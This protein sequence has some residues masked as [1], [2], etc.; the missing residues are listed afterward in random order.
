M[1]QVDGDIEIGDRDFD[2]LALL[3]E[4]SKLEDT[5]FLLVGDGFGVDQSCGKGG[6]HRG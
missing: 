3:G 2:R 4:V 1:C 5:R 6:S